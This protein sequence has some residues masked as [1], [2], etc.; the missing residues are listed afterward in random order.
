MRCNHQDFVTAL[1]QPPADVFSDA[2]STTADRRK[3]ID[4]DDDLH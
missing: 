4:N 3:F 1:N 2:S